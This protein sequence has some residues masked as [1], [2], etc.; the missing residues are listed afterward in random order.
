V[1][2]GTIDIS[3]SLVNDENNELRVHMRWEERD[4]PPVAAPRHKGF[5]RMVMD[6]IIGQALG[7]VSQAEF[8]SGGVCWTLNVPAASVIREPAHEPIIFLK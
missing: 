3:W 5:G 7:G 8:A 1:D 4:G 2:Q 6:R